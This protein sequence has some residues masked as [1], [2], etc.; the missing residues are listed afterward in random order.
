MKFTFLI[1]TFVQETES[2]LEKLLNNS[3][4]M[5]NIFDM[6]GII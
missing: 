6:Y 1:M 4:T 2:F 5:L 3:L